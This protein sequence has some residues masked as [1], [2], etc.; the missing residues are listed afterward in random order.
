MSAAAGLGAIPGRRR[1]RAS[2]AGI[3]PIVIMLFAA[4]AAAS[5]V[6]LGGPLR[7]VFPAVTALLGAWLL[8]N[9]RREDYLA[10][11]LW[12]FM[13]TP[14]LRRIVDLHAGWAQ[15][16]LLMLAPY[17]TAAVCIWPL[18]K[19]MWARGFAYSSLFAIV[20]ACAG[21]G[22]VV[23]TVDGRLLSAGF[24]VLRWAVPPCLGLFIASDPDRQEAYRDVVLR[25]MSVALVVLSAYG[26]A[27]FILAPRWDTLWMIESKLLSIGFPKPFEIRVFGTMN[28]PA[29]LAGYLMAGLL[30][31]VPSRSVMR[32]VSIGLGLVAL[33]LTL[34]RTAWLG[35]A[36]GV[37]FLVLLGASARARLSIVVG[38]FC[39]PI[40]L[41]GVA[42][43]PTGADIINTRLASLSEVGNDT[44]FLDRS[45]EYSDFFNYVLPQAPLGSGF[46]TNGAYQGY[47][48]SHSA[49][50]IVDGAILEIGAALGVFAGGAYLLA[51][52]ATSAIACWNSVRSRDTFLSSCGAIV[53][54]LTLSLIA[55][56]VTIGEGGILFW[57]AAGFCLARQPGRAAAPRFATA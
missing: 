21:Y 52:L 37:V 54:A 27:Q 38:V 19:T 31:I 10:F 42:Q 32:P 18:A 22:L 1:A 24:D 44:S 11:V 36:V 55:G 50:A 34:V 29:S 41:L 39:L 3:Y 8:S 14:F 23:A 16:N 48:D 49:A 5:T 33:L 51:I 56:T 45:S 12:T 35:L 7:P 28:S 2:R 40:V 4:W 20:L 15:L 46:G 30:W 53:A 6:G 26:I 9:G 57:L 43:I 25:T 17:T 47:V 13:L